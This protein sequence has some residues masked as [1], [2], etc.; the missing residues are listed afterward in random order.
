VGAGQNDISKGTEAGSFKITKDGKSYTVTYD[1]LAGFHLD[2]AHIFAS[3][4]KPTDCSPGHFSHGVPKTF[5]LDCYTVYFILHAKVS[6][7]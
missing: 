5:T 7:K 2:E 3:C 6:C 1:L 4:S